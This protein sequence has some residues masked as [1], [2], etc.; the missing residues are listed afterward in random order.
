MTYRNFFSILRDHGYTEK[1]IIKLDAIAYMS[2]VDTVMDYMENVTPEKL[3]S[4]GR[5]VVVEEPEM[6]IGEE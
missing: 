4:R 6:Y 5:D 2:A 3:R 1:Q